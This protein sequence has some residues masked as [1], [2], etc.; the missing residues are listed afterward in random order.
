MLNASERERYARQ[1]VLQEIGLTGQQKLKN[2]SVLII[3]MGGLGCP[4]AQYLGAAGVGTLGM[5]DFDSVSISNLQR[6]VLYATE[7]VGKLKVDVAKVKVQALNPFVKVET[8]P[9][10]CEPAQLLHIIESY[11]II[12]DCTDNYNSR[13]LI[14]DACV[15]LDKPFV[16][17][18]VYRFESQLAVYNFQGGPSYRCLFPEPPE[19]ALNCEE[20]GVIG[21]LTGITGT[22]QAN[23]IVKMIVGLGDVLSG[24]LL[25]YNSLNNQTNILSVYRDESQIKKVKDL[26]GVLSWGGSEMVCLINEGLKEMDAFT[27]KD[28]IEKGERVQLIDVREEADHES[29]PLAGECIPVYDIEKRVESI[30]VDRPVVL[31]CATGKRS[32]Q[33][34]LL[35]QELKHFSN[36][37][38]LKG[39]LATW[40]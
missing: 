6:Q 36:L 20:A 21:V 3:G 23:E 27:L 10:K 39:G 1:T 25:L 40:K 38:H 29:D 7:D 24:K 19:E 26:K 4:I 22:L 2:A 30:A 37:Y 31:Y 9:L 5:A 33:A 35:L 8:Y 15:T 16:S 34:I 17:A 12:A 14:N 28:K 18:S 11:D 32:A 13:Y